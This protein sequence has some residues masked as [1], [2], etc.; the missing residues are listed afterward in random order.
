MV[1]IVTDASVKPASHPKPLRVG[2]DIGSTTVKAVVL[3]QSDSL[4]DTLFSDYRRHHANVR[5][6]VAGLLVDIR[7]ELVELGR[8]DEPIRLS[9]TGSGGLAL[10]DNLHVPFIQE[11]IAE[12]EAIDKEYPQADVIIELGGEDAKITYLKPTP[13]QRMNGSCAGG[14]GAFIDQMSTLLDTDAAGLNE[15]AKSYENLYPIASRCGVFAK[16]DLQPLINDGAAK[17]DLAASIFTAVATQTIAGLASG[18]PI[19]GTVIFL[20]GPLFFMSELRAAFQRALE[21]KV[22]E[23]IVPTDAHL[24]VAYGSALQAD[25]DSDDQG[26]HF[27][28]YTCDEILK[29]LDE[30]KNLPS[31][32]PTMPPLFPTEADREDFNKRHHKEH[33]HIG[34]LEG[35][36]GPHFLG[37]DAGSTTIKATL[38]NDDRE[39]VWSSYANNEGCK[40]AAVIMQNG[41]DYSTG[42][43]NYFADAFAKMDGCEVVYTGTY[44]T[45]ET[46][47]NA[48][49][50]AAK[51]ADPDVLFIPSSITT[52][53]III[54]QARDMGI[55]A[56]IMAGDTWENATI[57]ENAGV[58]NCE[59]VALS[60]FFDE[61]DTDASE[62]VQGFKAYLNGDAEA[63]K[64]NG[65]ND[66]VA[67]VSALGYDAYM[68]IIE[69][70]KNV[71]GD[72]TG[73][74]VRDALASV[75]FDGV[76]GSISFD[77]NG[78]ANKDMAYIKIMS[79][80][81]FKFVGTQKTDGTFTPAA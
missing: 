72:I 23:F 2:L 3:D 58:E 67:A 9:I 80:G 68:A 45:N 32:T 15:M 40:K 33:I 10:A 62:F 21:G 65:N 19:H 39:I 38:V 69:A 66:T 63:L 48:I 75:S 11:V 61:N 76:T 24:Y 37:I 41:D 78:D 13:E 44:N 73:E 17:P 77:E 42:L 56:R 31:N 12:T 1:D 57:M 26:H 25:T 16:T 54:K 22:D 4:K 50:T 64:L 47:F 79:D 6:T 46:D 20:G 8:G 81:A 30:L 52:A 36:H 7:K 71:S 5:A 70:L 35:A 60:T 53:G 59:G 29:R 49:L 55:T 74:A 28:A 18:R 51:A 43:A 34:T 14:T 27:E